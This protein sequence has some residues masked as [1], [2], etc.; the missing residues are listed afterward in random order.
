MSAGNDGKEAGES[1]KVGRPAGE[2]IDQQADALST[3]VMAWLM[4]VDDGSAGACLIHGIH[5]M[6]PYDAGTT[7]LTVYYRNKAALLLSLFQAMSMMC[8]QQ[9][10]SHTEKSPLLGL[11]FIDS[12]PLLP[13]QQQQQQLLPTTTRTSSSQLK[14][15]QQEQMQNERRQLLY[16]AFLLA[17]L[18]LAAPIVCIIKESADRLFGSSNSSNSSSSSS[19]DDRV[20]ESFNEMDLL[21]TNYENTSPFS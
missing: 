21:L 10:S 6:C 1:E 2:Q 9:C 14:T 4:S 18:L 16:L 12:S 19:R 3:Q 15:R 11:Q 17:A 8:R 20:D 7:P 13:R 5:M